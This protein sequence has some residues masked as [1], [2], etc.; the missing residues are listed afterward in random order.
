M[1]V[2]IVITT[3]V[4]VIV[5]SK[6]LKRYSKANAPG[7][8]L[9]H[10]ATNQR[11]LFQRGVKRYSSVSNEDVGIVDDY[12]YC[13]GT[14]LVM[15]VMTTTLVLLMILVMTTIIPESVLVND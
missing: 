1:M 2:M 14:V 12:D 3:L 10:A 5:I 13:V 11:G 6:F 8:Q 15:I 7:H 9:N 4:F